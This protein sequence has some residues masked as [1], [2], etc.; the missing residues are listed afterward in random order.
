MAKARMLPNE[1]AFAK[2]AIEDFRGSDSGYIGF[3][4]GRPDTADQP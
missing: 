1:R 2:H 3:V 4:L